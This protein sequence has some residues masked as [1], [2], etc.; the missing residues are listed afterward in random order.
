MQKARIKLASIDI[1]KINETCEYIR[2]IAQFTEA[3]R[4]LLRCDAM[5]ALG[6][7]GAKEYVDQVAAHLDD[8]EEFV[9]A[10]AATALL[11]MGD[12]KHSRGIVAAVRASMKSLET[13]SHHPRPQPYFA[14]RI[15]LHS[16]V[17]ERQRQLTI[18]A[19]REWERLNRSS[20]N[21]H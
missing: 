19:M 5:I 1:N 4:P 12:Q 20:P 18:R 17:A 3:D 2:E 9:R 15:G 11:L 7:F 13:D 6:I 16:A 21:G 8:E 10:Y 14:L